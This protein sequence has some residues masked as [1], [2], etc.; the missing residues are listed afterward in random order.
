MKTTDHF[1]QA[2]FRSPDR[3]HIQLHWI[4]RVIDRPLRQEVQPNGRI[5]RW[6]R[7]PQLGGRVLRLIHLPEGETVHTA[8][9]DGKFR[10]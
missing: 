1:W 3:A 7:V 2:R 10:L 4:Q 8:F 9:V 6:G 5:R